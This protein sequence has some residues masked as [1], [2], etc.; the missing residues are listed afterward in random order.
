MIH[1]SRYWKD[2]LLKQADALRGRKRQRRWPEVSFARLEQTIMLSFYSIRKLIEAS[3]LS[4]STVTQQIPL[5]T[6][7]WT[8]KTVTRI[9]WH[10]IHQLY[11]LGSPSNESRDLLFLC[12]QIVHSYVFMPVFDDSGSLDGIM[13][14]SDRQRNQ[15]L[16]S[17]TL[18]A[19]IELF[20]RVG[21]D[22]PNEMRMVFT[23]DTQDYNVTAT[24]HMGANWAT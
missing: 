3:K 11:A 9:N 23:P 21:N 8:G 12:H 13:F 10:K 18:D 19:I 22:Y 24:M 16:Y 7:P 14:T 2:D 1:E 15:R 5:I 6:Y 4:D 17:M 20:E